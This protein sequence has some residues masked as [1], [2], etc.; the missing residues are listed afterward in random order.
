MAD[1]V[2]AW[3]PDQYLRFG[4]ERA[5]PFVDL[6]ARVGATQPASV[7]DLGCG[8]GTLTATLAERW[9]AARVV[10]VDRSP[11]M[12]ASAR[13]LR[14]PGLEFVVDDV[15][16]WSPPGP[17]DVVISNAALHWVPEH[18]P[19]LAAIAGWLAPGG[20]VAVQ[21]PGNFGAPSHRLLAELCASPRWAGRLADAADQAAVLAPAA[22]AELL[23]DAGLTPDVWETT[24]LHRL[25]GQDPVLEWVRGST[26]RPVLA[27]LDAAEAAAF[28]AELAPRLRAAYPAGRHGTLFPFRRI[29]A[30]G[31]RG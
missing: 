24:Y 29:F 27:R 26:L 2:P 25:T 15:R 4:D 13:T 23:A 6:L 3:D 17:V 7:V 9:P 20:W 1:P 31:R 18:G 30:V 12:I 21:V 8:P 5:R 11:E 14:R 19:L 22:Y 10:G 16:T 28:T